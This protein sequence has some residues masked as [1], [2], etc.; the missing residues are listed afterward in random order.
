MIS[1]VTVFCGSSDAKPKFLDLWY[2]A[3]D[4]DALVRYL[5]GYEPH[6]YGLKWTNR[7]R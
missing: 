4:V 5:E 1:S 6:R 2:P 7:A 3:P